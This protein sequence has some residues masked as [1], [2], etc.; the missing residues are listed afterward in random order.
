MISVV[1]LTAA[2]SAVAPINGF[3]IGLP[4]DRSTWLVDFHPSAT[5]GQRTAAQNVINTFD[6]T[7][8]DTRLAALAT[9]LITIKALLISA[10]PAQINTYVDNQVPELSAAARTLL[11]KILGLL[12]TAL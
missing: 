4:S 3:S 9:D 8:E 12:A 7:A 2:L 11:K 1:K 10:T 6:I 5:A